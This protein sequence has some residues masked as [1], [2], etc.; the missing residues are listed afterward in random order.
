MGWILGCR[1]PDNGCTQS[2]LLVKAQTSV[3]LQPNKSRSSVLANVDAHPASHC[4]AA[5][6]RKKRH[7]SRCSLLGCKK[8]GQIKRHGDGQRG[9]PAGGPL[10]YF[11]LA[12][13]KTSLC[14]V[15]VV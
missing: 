5:H 1:L 8:G 7:V 4:I 11:L 13:V 2:T 3:M 12:P 6:R 10:S 14:V 15:A 9:L